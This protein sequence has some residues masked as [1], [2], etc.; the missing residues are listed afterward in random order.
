MENKKEAYVAV[1]VGFPFTIEADR[2]CWELEEV[3]L[4]VSTEYDL[5]DNITIL[6]KE[7]TELN[8]L[9]FS[10]I[11][12]AHSGRYW[13]FNLDTTLGICV[14]A[15]LVSGLTKSTAAVDN[16]IDFEISRV[17]SVFAEAENKSVVDVLL[18]A[19]NA[20]LQYGNNEMSSLYW[21]DGVK[22]PMSILTDAITVI[23]PDYEYKTFIISSNGY[24][25]VFYNYSD[26]L[27]LQVDMTYDIHP[28]SVALPLKDCRFEDNRINIK[29]GLVLIEEG[30][31][32]DVQAM[33]LS[34]ASTRYVNSRGY[35]HT[36]SP[37]PTTNGFRA[38][39]RVRLEDHDTPEFRNEHGREREEVMEEMR[40]RFDD[41][42]DRNPH[43]RDRRRSRYDR[44]NER[45]SRLAIDLANLLDDIEDIKTDVD[46]L[47][48]H[49]NLNRELVASE[50]LAI[51]AT[52]TKELTCIISRLTL[53]AA[54]AGTSRINSNRNVDPQLLDIL[55]AVTHETTRP[56]PRSG[57]RTRY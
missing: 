57:R 15:T 54:N 20:A 10:G 1:N 22:C 19:L 11:V 35:V 14:I 21:V 16:N 42:R 31:L 7:L 25:K 29:K 13:S 18:S 17:M 55:D 40:D 37:Q 32:I 26:G 48:T 33:S 5:S 56:R 49:N 50:A 46:R 12:I 24:I 43:D 44:Y 9:T 30:W 8:E 41:R 38:R 27:E 52:I 4:D 34:A 2:S 6:S 47:F 3:Q 53:R 36:E 45:P 28:D 39:A 51:S 23:D